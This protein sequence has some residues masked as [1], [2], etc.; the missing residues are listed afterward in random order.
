MSCVPFLLPPFFCQHPVPFFQ[1]AFYWVHRP[2]ITLRPENS[3]GG[4]VEHVFH[5]IMTCDEP[6]ANPISTSIGL[7]V[8]FQ[9]VHPIH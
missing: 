2:A 8:D 5:G 6:T 4:Q 3:S 7:G 9:I 1:N